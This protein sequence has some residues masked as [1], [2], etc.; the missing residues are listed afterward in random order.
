VQI[1]V[2]DTG[3]GIDPDELP[4]VFDSFYRGRA[5]PQGTQGVGLGLAITKKLVELHGG[6]IWTDSTPRVGSRFY[7]TLPIRPSR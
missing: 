1:C 7:V 4:K 2:S 3:C 5:A 6:R